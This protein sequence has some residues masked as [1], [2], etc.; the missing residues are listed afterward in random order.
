MHSSSKYIDCME[1]LVISFTLTKDE[2]RPSRKHSHD[3]TCTVCVGVQTAGM[4]NI[5]QVLAAVVL[6]VS[7]EL[8]E[9]WQMY[10][11]DISNYGAHGAQMQW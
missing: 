8:R 9:Q 3:L 11:H 2:Q 4:W 7:H 1:K 5:L 6:V 10:H